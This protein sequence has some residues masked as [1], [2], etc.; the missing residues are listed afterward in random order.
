MNNQTLIKNEIKT[1][2]FVADFYEEIRYKKPYSWLY[3][4]WWF[5]KMI[6]LVNPPADGLI[7]DD[8]CGTGHLA[9]F[10]P[11]E[12]IIGLDISEG[13]LKYAR[14]RIPQVTKGDAQN[15][16]FGDEIFDCV[17]ARALLHHLPEPER[18]VREIKRVLKKGGRVIF[19][20][21]LYSFL[22][23]LPRKILKKTEH[24]SE[25]HKNLR[26]SEIVNM[27][28]PHLIIK[29]IYYFGYIAYPLLGF[30]DIF[31]SF[32]P[33]PRF[34][35]M[36]LAKFLVKVDELIALIPLLKKQAWGIMIVAEKE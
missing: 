28:K 27:I 19:C 12:K 15:L 16:P 9:E 11:S 13:M 8:G 34:L 1:Q 6:N 17:F 30:P 2:D 24:F 21:T 18:G 4:S 22:S 26:E 36:P 5:K 32:K 7:L 31:D 33:L 35:R 29:K 10:L 3:Q 20:D 25:E 23:V 14:K